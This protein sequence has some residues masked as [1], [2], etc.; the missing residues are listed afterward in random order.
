[1]DN[2]YQ[3]PRVV[4]QRPQ[5]QANSA[6]LAWSVVL[7]LLIGLPCGVAV[8]DFVSKT[9]FAWEVRQLPSGTS[10]DSGN[11][12]QVEAGLLAGLATVPVVVVI[13]C[14]VIWLNRKERQRPLSP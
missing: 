11:S 4:E 1:M 5:Q 6:F 3:P 12:V 14:V 2:P 13:T 9:V 7:G 10:L 8:Y